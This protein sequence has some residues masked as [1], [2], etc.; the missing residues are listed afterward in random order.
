MILGAVGRPLQTDPAGSFTLQVTDS[1]PG[2]PANVVYCSSERFGAGD[3]RQRVAAGGPAGSWLAFSGNPLLLASGTTA[4]RATPL[5]AAALMQRLEADGLATLAGIDGQFAIAWWSAREGKLRLVRD[6]FGMEP[7]HYCARQRQVL[8]ATRA[9]DAAAHLAEPLKVSMQALAEY[10]AHCYLPGDQTLYDGIDRVPA[11]GCVE[12]TAES[13]A[14]RIGQWYRLSYAR[15]VAPDER[16]IADR[17]RDL[18]DAGVSRRLS[19]DRIGV[20]ISGGMDSSSAA[21]FAR[22]HLEGTIRSYSFKCVGG[23]ADE[24]PYSRALA[25]ALQTQ[26]CEVEFGEQQALEAVNAAGA[27][28]M[29]F[30]DI[31]VE[32]GTWL[33]TQAAGNNIDYLLTGDGGDEIWASHP[34]YALQRII[35]WY[36]R[37]PLPRAV[38]SMLVSASGLVRDSDQKRNLAVILKRMLPEASYSKQLLHY[39]WKMYYTTGSL[40]ELVVPGLQS[41]LDATQPFQSALDSFAGYDGPAD[42]LSACLYSD[43]RGIS[44]CYFQRMFLARHFGIEVRMPFYDRDL[45]E[46]GAQ[47]PLHLKLEGIERTKRLFR[48]AMEGILPDIINHRGDKM[49]HSVPFKSWLRET[50]ALNAQVSETLGSARFLDRGLFRPEAVARLLQEHRARRHNHSHRIWALFILEHW[51]RQHFDS[52]SAATA[53]APRLNPA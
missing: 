17:Y 53:A 9:G 12:F 30:C 36:D 47:I 2:R 24:S 21:T 25:A 52:A 39:R 3:A 27:M 23:S 13:G 5:S 20:F 14:L 38:R 41:A 4:S 7:L 43:Y 37:V 45:V 48:M 40:R 11:G 6:R 19:D 31:G 44:S 34:V 50:G 32:I 35:S 51:F 10:L 1:T 16:A 46:F 8:F 33:L 22:R 28:D 49:G 26:H 42:G 15:Q 18:L 29:P